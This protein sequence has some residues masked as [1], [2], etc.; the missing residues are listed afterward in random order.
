MATQNSSSYTELGPE[1]RKKSFEMSL[2][3][4]VWKGYIV[5][6]KYVFGFVKTK[7]Y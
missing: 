2:W 7:A 3:K 4:F 1:T 6:S 5:V